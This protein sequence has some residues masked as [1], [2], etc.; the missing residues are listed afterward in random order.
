MN[1]RIARNQ[2]EIGSFS[3]VEIIDGLK[4]GQF[5]GSDLGW[6]ETMTE[7]KS[8]DSLFLSAGTP[9]MGMSPPVLPPS[10]VNGGLSAKAPV[11]SGLAIAALVLGIIS[12]LT[13]GFFAVGALAAIICGH[14][15]LSKISRSVGALKG[16]G[17]AITGLVMGYLSLILLGV[18]I[19]YSV[20]Q[21]TAVLEK[22]RQIQA[23]R[24]TKNCEVLCSACTTYAASHNGALPDNVEQLVDVGLFDSQQI[25]QM[26]T[27]NKGRAVFEY[28]GAGLTINS[29]ADSIIFYGLIPYNGKRI[30]GRLDGKIEEIPYQ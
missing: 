9:D 14:L 13:L 1:Y 7:W 11:N 27:D 15:A 8:L 22:S 24:T 20:S 17:K 2:T 28:R 18:V 26:M 29:P 5:L 12:L 16:R 4:S 19:V 10:I 6:N 23:V 21:A 3:Q 30:V 25:K